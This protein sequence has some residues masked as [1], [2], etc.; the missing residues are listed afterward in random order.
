M[1]GTLISSDSRLVRT[2]WVLL[3]ALALLGWGCGGGVSSGS[4]SGGMVAA[5]APSEGPPA[6]PDLK[7]WESACP[8]APAVQALAPPMAAATPLADTQT[9]GTL[10]LDL[11]WNMVS[12]P[13]AQVTSLQLGAGVLT[14]AFSWNGAAGSYVVVDLQ[15]PNNLASGEGTGRGFWI[16]TSQA[17]TI[18]YTGWPNSDTHA[19]SDVTL[20]AGW[21]MLGFPYDKDQAFSAVRVSASGSGVLQPLMDSVGQAV[22]P[23]NPGVLLYGSGFT[24]GNGGYQP[25]DLSVPTST[26]Q[27]S[28]AIWV[29]AHQADTL[30][31]YAPGAMPTLRTTAV[32]AGS[33]YTVSLKND[34]TVWAW[35]DNDHG[36]LGD[37]T[38]TER[39]APVQV[40]RLMGAT[41]VDAGWYHTVALKNDGTVWAWGDNAALQLGDGTTTE[42]HA[43]VQVPGLTGVT[44]VAGGHGH[45]VALKSDGTVWAWGWNGWGALGDGTM[46]DRPTPVRVS[47]LMGVTSVAPSGEHTAALKNDGTVWAWG[48]NN[49]G[50]LGDGTTTDRLTPVRVSGLTGGTAV[51]VGWQHTVALKNDGTVWAW[52]RNVSGALGDGTTTN[53]SVPVQVSGLT[54]VTAV[55][56]G[57]YHTLAL[58]NDGTVWAWGENIQGQLGD[59]T[60]TGCRLTPVRVSGLTGVVSVAGGNWHSLALKNDGTVWA[61]GENIQGQ[62]GDGTTT[63]RLTPVE[64]L[65]P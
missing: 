36:Q 25:T 61:W 33:G 16:Y 34:G 41:A 48:W 32:D 37:E 39:H 8:V 49:W 38:T 22:P 53:R 59:G 43:P 9:S 21:N 6:P 19:D 56:A 5:L 44:A 30:L 14:S 42:R 29:Y 28:K 62:L 46:T 3:L 60:R 17:S 4:V 7:D 10:S 31:H 11:G 45:T 12:F 24:Y 63:G 54:E 52:G 64:V 23:P 65:F 57:G 55:A 1:D 47:G 26:F 13:V 51:A 40:S 35:G 50:E 18:Q 20:A 27:V 2:L 15:N 58:K